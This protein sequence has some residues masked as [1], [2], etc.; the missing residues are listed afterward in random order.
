MPTE[1]QLAANRGNASHSTGP[2]TD[3][4]K[5]RSARNALKHGFRSTDFTIPIIDHPEEVANLKA[6]LVSVYQPGNAQEM[7]ALERVALAQHQILRSS[8][9]E[10]G[11][12][13]QSLD[14]GLN[15]DS[16][17]IAGMS[18]A[19]RA[20]ATV[21]QRGN[22]GLARGFWGIT[23]EGNSWALLLRYQA[24]A[25]RLY[26]RAIEDFDRLKKLRSELPNEDLTNVSNEPISDP[27]PEAKADTSPFV[28]TNPISDP[29]T[30]N[31]PKIPP[32]SSGSSNSKADLQVGAESPDPAKPRV[33]PTI[34][35][36]PQ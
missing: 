9:L 21:P 27:Q 12:L 17:L 18:Q 33:S 36:P 26:R 4:G 20:R 11:M 16:T 10:A 25:E 8:R 22:I 30:S 28:Q 31:T 5:A 19:M 3:E 13:T 32:T 24:Q 15:D 2:R 29:S 1:K 35:H 23:R 7:F 14:R 6:D 34:H